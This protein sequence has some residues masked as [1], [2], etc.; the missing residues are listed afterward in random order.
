MDSKARGQPAPFDFLILGKCLYR[1]W[2]LLQDPSLENF[3][4]LDPRTM[5]FRFFFSLRHLIQHFE[6]LASYAA[7]SPNLSIYQ[8]A[9][10]ITFDPTTSDCS[11]FS[12]IQE[13]DSVFRQQWGPQM[14]CSIKNFQ[15]DIPSTDNFALPIL[16]LKTSNPNLKPSPIP[17]ALP[18]PL[19]LLS[20]RKFRRPTNST[21]A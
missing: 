4:Q 20:D 10:M 21:L 18:L 8:S 13:V 17:A 16:P 7:W 15:K 11:F 2:T 14:L 5:T 9:D 1:L 3:W 12:L 19:P 6:A